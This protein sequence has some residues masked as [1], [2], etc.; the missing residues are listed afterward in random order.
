V[1][2]LV[3]A[4]GALLDA[5]AAAAYG[6]TL[7]AGAPDSV[8]SSYR[9]PDEQMELFQGWLRR[10]PGYNFALHPSKS[11]HC[12]GLALDLRG[13]KAKTWFRVHGRP[14][15]WLFTDGSEDWHVAYRPQHDTHVDDRPPAPA[16]P[17]TIPQEDPVLIVGNLGKPGT[18]AL[19][20]NDG[21]WALI[22]EAA[23]AGA[24]RK[25]GIPVADVD[26]VT[27]DRICPPE[28]RRAI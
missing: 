3:R 24:L 15:G 18:V 21:S 12:R 13:V 22:Q 9:D 27:W 28:R 1:T 5:P 8:T 11:D 26:A 19:V 4:A 20:L 7:A 23:S 16:A 6:R 2:A 25:A 17:P 14:Y 10:L